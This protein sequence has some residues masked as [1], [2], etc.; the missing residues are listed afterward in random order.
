MTMLDLILTVLS[1]NLVLF[2][3]GPVLK[4]LAGMTE[5][6]FQNLVENRKRENVTVILK[7]LRP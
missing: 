1:M 2:L 6:E 5:S 4:V 3:A 7:S